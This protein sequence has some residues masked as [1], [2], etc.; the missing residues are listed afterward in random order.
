[1]GHFTAQDSRLIRDFTMARHGTPAMH[2]G[3]MT[4]A[5]AGR[6]RILAITDWAI[7]MRYAMVGI[8]PATPGV[9]A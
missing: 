7:V 6:V 9:T 1:V 5:P 4:G 3:R 2:R 8:I